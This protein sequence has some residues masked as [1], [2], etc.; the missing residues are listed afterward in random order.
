MKEIGPTF[1]RSFPLQRAFVSSYL[2]AVHR[3]GEALSAAD[4]RAQ[5]GLGSMKV[6]AALGYCRAAGLLDANGALT[7]LGSTVAEA[8]PHLLLTDSQWLLHCGLSG[9][10]LGAP[11]FWGQLWMNL[12]V[13]DQ[14]TR[15]DL[16]FLIRN[17][18]PSGFV[19]SDS[20]KVC[21]TAFVSTYA[22]EDCL[23]QL[24]LLGRVKDGIQ[25]G[26]P[27]TEPGVGVFAFVLASAWEALRP[28]QITVTLEDFLRD[29]KLP[30]ILRASTDGILSLMERAERRGDIVL[31]R[32]APPFQIGRR[33]EEIGDL[34]ARV[35][36]H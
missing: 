3:A 25:C 6:P 20:A 14:R 12:L 29:S 10:T 34:A 26:I 7:I 2:G 21:A 11:V 24:G 36:E 22:Q 4:A 35:Y 17:S 31:H 9:V 1:H 15:A 8:D 5:T 30:Q 16:E 18:Y 33:W 13:G 19:N 28:N 32:S 23:G 27:S